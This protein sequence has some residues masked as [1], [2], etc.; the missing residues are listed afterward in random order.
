[1]RGAYSSFEYPQ[2]ILKQRAFGYPENNF[3]RIS[4]LVIIARPLG[5]TNSL[6][7]TAAS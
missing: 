5:R 3:A 6:G 1:M 4:D 7:D 2:G